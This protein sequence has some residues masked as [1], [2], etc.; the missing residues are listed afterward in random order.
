MVGR[1]GHPERVVRGKWG[2]R[3]VDD[4]GPFSWQLSDIA[5]FLALRPAMLGSTVRT[6]LEKRFA[7]HLKQT[8][9]AGA[10]L[11]LSVGFAVFTSMGMPGHAM[12]SATRIPTTVAA[13][14]AAI[15]FAASGSKALWARK[16]LSR[17]RK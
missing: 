16:E 14:I 17:R 8:I 15:V 2:Y 7:R 5:T 4:D 3:G 6:G 11:G 1:V 10:V 9:F 13:S 12:W